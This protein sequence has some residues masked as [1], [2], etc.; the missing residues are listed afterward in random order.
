MENEQGVT[1]LETDIQMGVQFLSLALELSLPLR[2]SGAR[3]STAESERFLPD[4]GFDAVKRIALRVGQSL[5]NAVVFMERGNACG[6][7]QLGHELGNLL[8]PQV[9]IC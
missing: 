8:N 6:G 2:T 4:L 3:L 5:D 9:A 1:V 7:C